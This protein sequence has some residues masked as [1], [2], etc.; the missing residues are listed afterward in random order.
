MATKNKKASKSAMTSK[1]DII[2]IKPNEMSKVLLTL[3]D[4][5]VIKRDYDLSEEGLTPSAIVH[6]ITEI[7]ELYLK[8][9]Q[10]ILQPEE[11][12]AVYECNEFDENDK[13]ELFDLYKRIIILHR[14]L[15]KSM[16]VADENNYLSTIQ[17]AH[18]EMQDVKPKMIEILTKMQ[19]SWKTETK[20]D[21]HKGSMQ[22]FG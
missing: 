7:C 3:K 5:D 9:I 18:A 2:P 4:I 21:S 17:F 20:K 1:A 8:I 22:Y 6:K 11:F 19:Q 10:Q 15:L 13:S 16:I 12:H 14:E